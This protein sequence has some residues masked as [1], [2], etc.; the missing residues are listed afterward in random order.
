MRLKKADIRAEVAAHMAEAGYE[1]GEWD[2]RYGA[3]LVLRCPGMRE[4]TI[5]FKAGMSRKAF[6]RRLALI[7]PKGARIQPAGPFGIGLQLDLEDYIATLGNAGAAETGAN[8]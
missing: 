8:V 7:P 2:W 4:R 3:N 6:Q 5:A 1:P